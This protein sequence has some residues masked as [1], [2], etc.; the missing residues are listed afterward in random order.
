MISSNS[1]RSFLSNSSVDHGSDARRSGPTPAVWSGFL[2]EFRNHISAVK[3]LGGELAA[4]IPPALAPHVGPVLSET[5]RNVQ[6]LTALV[7]L[8]DA[9]V[10][11]GDLVIARLGDV[12]DRATRLAAPAAGSALSIVTRVPRDTGVRNR[13]AV[14]E[15]LLAAL[16]LEVA[17]DSAS[18]TPRVS[19]D[20]DVGR[21]GLVLEVAGESARAEAGSWRL[22]L[23]GDLAAKL[24]ATLAVPAGASS[25]LI[26]FH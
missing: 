1:P 21:R 11:T 18:P 17:R 8:V 24:D 14:L 25:Y 9:S 16:V 22:A 15:S 19:I 4:G 23:A 2:H 3:R 7:A 26:Q 12:V 13:G 10:Q 20:A 5:E 6:G